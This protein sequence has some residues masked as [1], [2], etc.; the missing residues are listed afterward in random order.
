MS[1][2]VVIGIPTMEM[3]R[4]AKFYD[5]L[6]SIDKPEGTTIS[7]AHG[8]S[9]AANR[10]AIIDMALEAD[11]TH[12]FFIDDDVLIPKDA[13]P[14]LLAHDKDIVSGLYLMRNFP[15]A[16]IAFNAALNDGRC[17][18]KF[19]RTGEKG[20]VEVVGF[21]LGCCLIKMD[22]FKKMEKPWIR[23]GQ[24]N[25][26]EWNDDIEF[27]NRARELYDYKLWLDLDIQCGHVA[28]VTLWPQCREDGDWVTI[29]DTQ[30]RGNAA[31][32]AATPQQIYGNDEYEKYVDEHR[33][34]VTKDFS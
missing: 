9:P 7:L 30:G 33:H 15:H 25:A 17:R 8:Q 29:Y 6:F 16:P 13:L 10:N 26:Q 22:V 4:I 14:R 12:I 31:F 11:A 3:A 18:F 28:T 32:L 19:L 34:L 27:F 5:F 24:L 1:Q 20:L 2:K 23:I 21:G